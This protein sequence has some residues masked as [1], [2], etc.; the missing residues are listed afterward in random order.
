MGGKKQL[1][2]SIGHACDTSPLE[3]ARLPARY[4]SWFQRPGLP[5]AKASTNCEWA[6]GASG[7]NLELQAKYPLPLVKGRP[8]STSACAGEAFVRHRQQSSSM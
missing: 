5:A 8:I 1:G 4:G 2:A 7:D 3:K 6:G